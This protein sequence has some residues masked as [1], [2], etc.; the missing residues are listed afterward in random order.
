M[1]SVDGPARSDS[2][3]LLLVLVYFVNHSTAPVNLGGAER[4]LI[5]LVEEWY[6]R[7]PAFEAFF[8]TK[9]P[10][11]KFIAAIE[12]RGWNYRAFR[13]RGWTIQKE[14][15]PTNEITY[16][17]HDDYRATLE[18]IS[19]LEQRRP[20][21][22]VTNT[23]VAPWGAFAA[24]VLGIPHA[25]FVREYGDLDHGLAFQTGRR[26]TFEDI[27]LLSQAVFTNSIA[28][29]KHIGQYLDEAKV[30]VVYPQVN[31]AEIEGLAG[32]PPPVR[33]FAPDAGLKVTVV[34]RLSE[35]KGQWRAIDAIA[36]L[37]AREITASLCLVG[38][39]ELAGYD[40]QLMTRARSLGIADRVTIVGEQKNPFPFIAA[41]DVCVTPSGIEAFGRSTLE[42]MLAAKPV[43]AS[44]G[45][46]SV[47]LVVSGVTGYHFSADDT[48]SLADGLEHYAR[49]P[50][51]I[52]RHGKAGA[53]RSREL[54]SGDYGNASA[55]DRLVQTASLAPYRLPNIARYWFALPG[56]YFST[57]ARG[58]G[59]AVSFIASR[60]PGRLRRVAHRTVGLL[61]R[62]P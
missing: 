47:E 3:R 15:P 23:I 18:I 45:G 46:G 57:S 38:S 16:F 7:D 5:R 62:S 60:L 58:P 9:A 19:F 1:S 34:G 55:I 8:I 21:L 30:S 56:H 12:E 59:I 33:P 42:Y 6:A 48:D 22:V 39:H 61:R 17:A 24:A 36:A 52:A 13:Y 50:D 29:K 31:V 26:Q 44:A 4:S 27:G 54:M 10:R 20:D 14:N 28:L 37:A 35:T 32:E 41:A 53:A 40:A 43:V 2:D 51:D 11:G 49:H 25:W